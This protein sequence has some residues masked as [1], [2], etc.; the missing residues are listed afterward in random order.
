MIEG[1]RRRGGSVGP[2]EQNETLRPCGD[3]GL[4]AEDFPE[5]NTGTHNTPQRSEHDEGVIKKVDQEGPLR[6]AA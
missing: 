3:S 5:I 6:C 1:L 2:L 4:R